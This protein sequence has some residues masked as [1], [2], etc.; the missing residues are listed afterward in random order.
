[1]VV[2]QIRPKTR[3]INVE[4]EVPEEWLDQDLDINLSLHNALS[5]KAEMMLEKIKSFGISL[6]KNFK[7]N[8][9]ECYDRDFS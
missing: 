9:D 4:I 3:K 8:R 2:A 5:P 6:P 7:F 1:M